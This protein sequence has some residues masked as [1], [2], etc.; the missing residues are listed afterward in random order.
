MPADKKVALVTGASSGIGKAVALDLANQGYRLCLTA[1]RQDR[2]DALAEL[3][4]DE[5]DV[6]VHAA[7]MKKESDIKAVF[8]RVEDEWGQIDV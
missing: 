4:R 7:D 3:L 5:T 8:R 1:R 6:R 2:L